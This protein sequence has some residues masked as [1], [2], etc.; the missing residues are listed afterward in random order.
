L[1]LEAAVEPDSAYR[2]QARQRLPDQRRGAASKLEQSTEGLDCVCGVSVLNKVLTKRVQRSHSCAPHPSLQAFGPWLVWPFRIR[3]S[4]IE[5]KG[6]L[7]ARTLTLW[8]RFAR[9]A[10]HQVEELDRIEDDPGTKRDP[11]AV[12][13]GDRNGRS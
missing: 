1:W 9:C 8:V 11:L 2:R 13:F 3:L 10:I 5:H 7:Q 4:A 6:R 12:T